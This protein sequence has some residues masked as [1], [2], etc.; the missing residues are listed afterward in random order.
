[1][2]IS[3]SFRDFFATSQ[4]NRK[5]LLTKSNT[6]PHCFQHRQ[7]LLSSSAMPFIIIERTDTF[8]LFFLC[9]NIESY[10]LW[11]CHFAYRNINFVRLGDFAVMLS[12]GLSK[13]RSLGLLFLSLIPMYLGMIV[14]STLS[15]LMDLTRIIFAVTSGMFLFLALV[16]MVSY[17]KDIVS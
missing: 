15:Q 9:V 5:Y 8:F 10:Y 2:E 13:R 12:T 3:L 16:E 7:Y 14:G 1:M 4:S 17:K 11:C 6:E